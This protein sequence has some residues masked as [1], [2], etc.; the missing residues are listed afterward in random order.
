M[1]NNLLIELLF[2]SI[3]CNTK[4]Y[5]PKLGQKTP[6]TGSHPKNRHFDQKIDILINKKRVFFVDFFDV[7][8]YT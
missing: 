7:L 4:Y 1:Y 2:K 8:T 6:V 3:H 5:F